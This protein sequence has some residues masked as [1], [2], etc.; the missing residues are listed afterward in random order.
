MVYDRYGNDLVTAFDQTGSPGLSTSVTQPQN[1]NFTS[2]ARYNGSPSS[3]PVLPAS[4]G[5]S[6]PYTPAT[7]TGGFGEGVGISN[8]LVAPYSF[9]L[10]ATYARE[11]PGK[12]TFCETSTKLASH[13]IRWPK[14]P[15]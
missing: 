3:Y 9:I 10:N 15:T 13:P 11:L 7:I 5:G 8:N 4:S 14:I 12:L 1:T 6:F 2:A